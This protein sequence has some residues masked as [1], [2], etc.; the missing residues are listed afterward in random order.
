[1]RAQ[2]FEAQGCQIIDATLVPVPKQRNTREVNQTIKNGGIPERWL[3]QPNRLQKRDTDA[4]WVKKNGANHYGYMNSISV[5]AEHGFIRKY[6]LTPANVHDRQMLP[7]L[8]D[9]T[10]GSDVIWGDSAYSGFL[11]E[12]F[13]G[14]AGFYSEIHEK[15]VRGRPLSEDA[16]ARKNRIRSRNVTIL[17]SQTRGRQPRDDGRSPRVSGL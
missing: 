4:R 10:N 6:T 3:E 15:G 7:A 1:M 13:L 17:P 12:A 9:S 8:L 11:F 16:K 2:G 14:A 5:D